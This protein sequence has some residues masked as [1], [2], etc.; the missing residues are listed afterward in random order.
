MKNL[1]KGSAA[2]ALCLALVLGI[3]TCKGSDAPADNSNMTGEVQ[4]SPNPP[5]FIFNKAAGAEQTGAFEIGYM[6]GYEYM[7]GGFADPVDAFSKKNNV[8]VQLRAVNVLEDAL[9][10]PVLYVEAGSLDEKMIEKL[11]KYVKE[12]KGVL[13]IQNAPQ[14]KQ[15][16]AKLAPNVEWRAIDEENP[17]TKQ[18]NRLHIGKIDGAARL[19]M[20]EENILSGLANPG[21][22]AFLPGVRDGA[23]QYVENALSEALANGGMVE[24]ID[25]APLEVAGAYTPDG[26]NIGIRANQTGN[27]A[28]ATLSLKL[29][30]VS[31]KSLGDYTRD[32]TFDKKTKEDSFSF[33]TQPIDNPYL[34]RLQVEYKTGD[35]TI[36]YTK[37]L[38]DVIGIMNVKILGQNEVYA[39]SPSSVRVIAINERDNSPIA[40]A[41]VSM[42]IQTGAE[43]ISVSGKTDASGTLDLPFNIG[44]V[45]QDALK[46]E[47]DVN[48]ALGTAKIAQD[49]KIKRGYKIMLNTD[50]PIYKP[51]QIMYVRALAMQM[52]S[53]R[54]VSGLPVLLEIEDAK[55]NKLFKEELPLSEFGIASKDFP[56]ADELNLGT[57]TVRATVAGSESQEKKVDV[58][59]YVLPK[60]KVDVKPEKTFYMP[61]D[62]VKGEIQTDYFFGKPVANSDVKID[63]VVFEIEET[64]MGTVQ[65]KTDANGNFKFEYQLKDY[66]VG[67]PLTKGDAPVILNVTVTDTAAQKVEKSSTITVSKDPIHVYAI[68]ESGKLVPGVENIVYLMAAY[69]DGSPAE[70]ATFT[71]GGKAID[72]DKLGIATIT[73]TP[74][75]QPYI[76]KVEVADKRGAKAT[77]DFTFDVN[78]AEEQVLLR[79]DKV[80]TKVGDTL[81][82]TVFSSLG[83]GSV[84]LDII[85]DGQTVLTKSMTLENGKATESID[86][87]TDYFGT[88][89][90]NAYQI[91]RTGQIVRDTKSLYVARADD[92]SIAITPDKETY[93]PGEKATFNFAVTG[94]DG[95]PLLT[96]LGVI[97]V[98]EAV[99]ALS[100]MQPGLE[101]VYFTLEKEIMKPRYEIHEFVPDQFIL[102]PIRPEEKDRLL[103]A[104]VLAAAAANDVK[105]SLDINTAENKIDEYYKTLEKML[106]DHAAAMIKAMQDWAEKA[107]PADLAAT[108]SLRDLMNAL[109]KSGALNKEQTQDPWG[110]DIIFPGWTEP[111]KAIIYSRGPD[112]ELGTSD[113]VWVEKDNVF[114]NDKCPAIQ[115]YDAELWKLAQLLQNADMDRAGMLQ[116]QGGGR[117]FKGGR[118][119]GLMEKNVMMD[120]MP[121]PEAAMEGAM[122]PNA[123]GPA[124]ATAEKPRLRQFFPETL[125]FQPQI[126]TD[127]DGKASLTLDMADSITTWRMSTFASSMAGQ[128]GSTQ[129]GIRV[130]QDF[131]IDLNLPVALTLNDY[132]EVPVAVYNYLDK[133]QKVTLTLE[134]GDDK[135]FDLTGPEKVELTLGPNAV[136]VAHFPVKATKV[137]SH[138]FTVLAEGSEGLKDYIKKSIDIEPD[139]KMFELV[140]NGKLANGDAPVEFVATI[141]PEAIPDA[142]KIFVKIYPGVMAQIQEGMDRMLQMPC[143]CFE[144]TS[145]STY[146]NVLIMDYMKRTKKLTP[147]IQMKAEEYVSLG[148]QRLVSFE[149]EGGGFSWFGDS[150]AN[151]ILTSYGLMEFHDLSQ[152]YN[153]DPNVISRTQAWLTGKQKEGGNWEPDAAYL[154]QESWGKIQ[155]SNLLVTAYIMWALAHTKYTGPQMDKG[156]AYMTAH[157]AE[158]DNAYTLALMLN[159]YSLDAKKHEKDLEA[160]VTKLLAMKKSEGDKVWWEAGVSSGTYSEGDS[161]NVETTAMIAI[162]LIN[163]E[164]QTPLVGQIMNYL[165]SQKSPDGG[166]PGTQATILALRA[167]LLSVAKSQEKVNGEVTVTVGDA[168]DDFAIEPKNADMYHLLDFKSAT[169]TG[170]NKVTLRFDGEGGMMYQVV[171]RY[172]MPWKDVEVPQQEALTIDVKYDKTKLERDDIV[173]ANVT[174]KNNAP[175]EVK[176][177]MVDLGIPPGFEVQ[178]D[179]LWDLV[180]NGKIQ[181]F[182]M[183]GRQ[184]ILYLETMKSGEALEL[185][186]KMQAKFVIKAKAPASTVYQYYNPDKRAESQS[187]DIEVT[188]Q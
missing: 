114:K 119:G 84:Y 38:A 133:E 182:E 61:G 8:A 83:T 145:S 131:F 175:G 183:T 92:L 18:P 21:I 11:A 71:I 22:N 3:L 139:G 88:L 136:S 69:P 118:G 64:I 116:Q 125:L 52:P 19:F 140:Q 146:P 86:L 101:K 134:I 162:G 72:A 165:I 115:Q 126:L 151:Q 184:I 76:M 105:Y 97:I 39:N 156:F 17:D 147:E 50:K 117:R 45:K 23:V 42:N 43:P 36:A 120:A 106:D 177:V 68:P 46:M 5:A 73:T 12:G 152:V 142:Y 176:M 20:V 111:T 185:S 103:A 168:R 153:I 91:N 155:N 128:L 181:R 7:A 102:N 104:Q 170:D 85:R 37:T 74:K 30:D 107:A 160:V 154:H 33:K 130:F 53:M 34:Y 172:Y 158:A 70:G 57:W 96:A 100:E 149:V 94:T 51:G 59:R 65:G 16:A 174:I 6:T 157:M 31:N 60:F 122:P 180:E 138:S 35:I 32:I 55:G 163:A 47:V 56:L 40:N 171:T 13:F 93:L 135:W 132:V 99:F 186:Y 173:T 164:Q 28:A 63:F 78:A 24:K 144:Q 148:Y 127:K 161:A 98:D 143:G 129:S 25:P 62:I 81:N 109:V 150:P 95:K 188:G 167:L 48:S 141:P 67:H 179:S 87:G 79:L 90:V 27:A 41:A 75:E 121:M 187:F 4:F 82:A 108:H 15:F 77:A 2:M 80:F 26:V 14:F 112:G 123:N 137:G 110:K 1:I 89:L 113:D 44:A 29:L 49:L 124:G 66:F 58:K 166:W 169:K 54:P 10:M 159:A 9:N 178:Q